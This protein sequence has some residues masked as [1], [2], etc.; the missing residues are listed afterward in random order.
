[1]SLLAQNRL[2]EFHAE[3]EHLQ[4]QLLKGPTNIEQDVYLAFPVQLE[5]YL[6][7]G[8]YQKII[9]LEHSVPAASYVFFTQMLMK[10]VR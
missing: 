4:R 9:L 1:M 5:R 8:S 6:V 7:E 3:V 2:A 10:T